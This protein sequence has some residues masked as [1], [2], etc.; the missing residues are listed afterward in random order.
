MCRLICGVTADLF[1]TYCGSKLFS[2]VPASDGLGAR[3]ICMEA[4]SMPGRGGGGKRG[5]AREQAT[6]VPLTHHHKTQHNAPLCRHVPCRLA[7]WTRGS[8]WQPPPAAQQPR[9]TQWAQA[10]YT[11]F[12]NSAVG[13]KEHT[14]NTRCWQGN[15]EWGCVNVYIYMWHIDHCSAARASPSCTKH[16]R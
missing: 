13:C 2:S 12:L 3:H 14:L 15:D 1:P 7:P 6:C 4:S 16:T 9:L 11:Q 5:G 10:G 8:N